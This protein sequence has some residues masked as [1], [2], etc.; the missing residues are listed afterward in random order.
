[1]DYRGLHP[2]APLRDPAAMRVGCLS[3]AD[4]LV[5]W[6][7]V[8]MPNSYLGARDQAQVMK[9]LEHGVSLWDYVH[10]SARKKLQR[11]ETAPPH[12]PNQPMHALLTS[13]GQP[14][15]A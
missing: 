7:N 2:V 11:L 1:M 12:R 10:P 8:V 15:M 4:A 3:D 13:T 9:E 14:M 5:F 6:R